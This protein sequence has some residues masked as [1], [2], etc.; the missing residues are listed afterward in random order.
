VLKHRLARLMSLLVVAVTAVAPAAYAADKTNRPVKIVVAYAAGGGADALARLMAQRLQEQTGQPFVVEN[1]PGAGGIVGAEM[2]A[3]SPADGYTLLLT[4]TQVVI[5]PSMFDKLPYD[6]LK[7]LK[8][9][10]L[11]TSVPLFI[12]VKKTEKIDS[13]KD[14]IAQ[15]KANPGKFS[16][17][18]PGIGSLHHIAMESLKHSLGVQITHVPYKGSGQS[19]VGFL[20]GDVQVLVASLPAILQHFKTGNVKLLAVSSLQRS[21]QAPDVPTIA[22]VALPGFDFATEIGMLAPGGT[23]PDVVAKLNTEIVRALKNPD[24]VQRI[25]DVMGAVPVGSTSEAYNKRLAEGLDAYAKAVKISGAK[26]E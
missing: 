8:G 19:V 17:G 14:L 26:A 2:V 22:E 25:T 4:D 6:T 1:K 24:S 23:P 10:S 15:A 21:P 3:K 13:L 5:T 11:M 12:A 7:D 20:A 16:Y 9:I 18:S